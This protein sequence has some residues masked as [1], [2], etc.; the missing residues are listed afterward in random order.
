MIYTRR[1][2]KFKMYFCQLWQIKNKVWQLKGFICLQLSRQDLHVIS[3]TKCIFDEFI[4]FF[5]NEFE[6]FTKRRGR[7][8]T[9]RKN[10]MRVVS[11]PLGRFC[12]IGTLNVSSYPLELC[13][14]L[15]G[16]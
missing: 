9:T 10:G 13:F 6:H 12:P 16:T 8:F 11:G 4:Q 7:L 1:N 15:K 2:L 3:N 5:F 14:N